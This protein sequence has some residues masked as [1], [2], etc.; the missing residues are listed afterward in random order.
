[1]LGAN[2]PDASVAAEDD[3]NRDDPDFVYA[4]SH[5]VRYINPRSRVHRPELQDQSSVPRPTE[6]QREI[7]HQRN[8]AIIPAVTTLTS[9]TTTPTFATRETG[10]TATSTSA[11]TR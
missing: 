10:T 1:M 4:P 11:R 9:T 8:Q 2:A 3:E 6:S 5:N 7:R